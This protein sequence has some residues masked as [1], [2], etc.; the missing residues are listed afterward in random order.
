MVCQGLQAVSELL[1]ALCM[2]VAVVLSL[3]LSVCAC[4]IKVSRTVS[5]G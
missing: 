3:R 4:D 2:T 5:E 1:A